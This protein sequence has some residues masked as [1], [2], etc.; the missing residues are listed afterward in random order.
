MAN[1]S[2]I[3]T[4]SFCAQSYEAAE[5]LFR[6]DIG[7]MPPWICSACV[8]GFSAVIRVHRES[9]ALADGLIAAHNIAVRQSAAR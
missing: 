7:G 8:D 3:P 5:L 4:C 9:P 2:P 1:R 6:S